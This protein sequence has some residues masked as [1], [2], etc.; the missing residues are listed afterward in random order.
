MNVDIFSQ[1]FG[2][3]KSGANTPENKSDILLFA[4]AI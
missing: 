1:L 3:W 2:Y 4:L